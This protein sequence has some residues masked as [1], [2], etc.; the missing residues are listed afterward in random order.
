MRHPDDRSTLSYILNHTTA[1]NNLNEPSSNTSFNSTINEGNNSINPSVFATPDGRQ[2]YVIWEQIMSAKGNSEIFLTSSK[3]YGSSFNQI[4][5]V[6][7]PPGIS[8]PSYG[9]L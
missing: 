4:F 3:D 5:N 2:I 6:S 9:P 8:R 1:N 7:N